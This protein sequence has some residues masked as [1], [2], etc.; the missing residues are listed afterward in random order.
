V[1]RDLFFLSYLE[2]QLCS[3]P[4]LKLFVRSLPIWPIIS[5][6]LRSD[7]KLP[8]KPASG[9]YIL[10]KNA[11]HYRT[12]KNSKI[13]LDAKEDL[14][15]RVLNGLNVQTQDVYS[16][17]FEDVEF[18]SKSDY[19]YLDFLKDILDDFR[20]VQGLRDKR[21]FPSFTGK[22]KKI[23]DLYDH[24]NIVYRTV[25][26][27]NQDMFLDHNISECTRESK[28]LSSIGFK[29]N[30][31]KDTF[32]K[33]VKKI[34]ELQKR[35]KPPPDIRYRGFILVDHLYNNINDVAFMDLENNNIISRIP[36]VP[37]SKS[38]DKP[39]SLNYS[40][41]QTLECFDSVILPDYKEV[42][43]SQMSLIAEDVIPP[44][45]VLK[46]YPSLGKPKPA[47]VVEHLRYLYE[48]LRNNDEW[49]KNWVEIFKHN[50]YEVY[51]WL[52]QEC[53]NDEDLNLKE[54]IH[55][56]DPLF[57]NFNKDN[58]PFKSENWVSARELVLNSEPS[59]EKYVN[60]SLA[61]YPT[62]L[63][64]AGAKEVKRPNIE[65]H[66]RIHDQS[67][68]NKTKAIDSLFD[69]QFSLN[70]A[71]FIVK[72][73]RIKASRYMLAISSSIIINDIEYVGDVE[74]DSVRV[75]L[76]YL[77]GQNIDDAIKSYRDIQSHRYS[78]PI[79]NF[80]R[81]RENCFYD[82]PDEVYYYFIKMRN[83]STIC[84]L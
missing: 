54:Y 58:D 62:M 44:Q 74:P 10:P 82:E 16:Y 47:V 61:K 1:V 77:Y 13:Y 50:V 20:I 70:D 40:R 19:Y 7:P 35:L 46:K 80:A 76:R 32:I 56:Y 39:Y 15:R 63:K 3:D 34:D 38:L 45:H 27:G 79:N 14:T 67:Y 21:C 71:T 24:D 37:I 72:G 73:E 51:N 9:S 36:F 30:I 4:D 43:W 55:S 11:K 57:L 25:F 65:I 23:T 29:Y 68:A 64:R 8:L 48:I 6:P 28:T 2:G 22:T 5:D 26:S 83:I 41:S 69:P 17:T 66:V 60:P 59:E 33:C 75:L 18:P 12:K 49:K 53:L 31:D 52:E 84:N 42:A 81:N 78:P